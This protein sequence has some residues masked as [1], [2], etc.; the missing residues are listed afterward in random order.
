MIID[1]RMC[2][3][4]YKLGKL[5]ETE[6]LLERARACFKAVG[7]ENWCICSGALLLDISVNVIPN[8]EIARM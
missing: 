4:C 8:S 7:R 2:D 6:L 3:I 5:E 1:Y